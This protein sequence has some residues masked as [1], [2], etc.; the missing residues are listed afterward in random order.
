MRRDFVDSTGRLPKDAQNNEYIVSIIDNFSR[1]L[2]LYAVNDL[3]ANTFARCLLDFTGH[4]GVS[5]ELLI[6][7]KG[8]QFANEIIQE[9]CRA[10]GTEQVFT[11]TAAKKDI[12]IVERSIR[13]S[14][15][16]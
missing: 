5:F 4:Y 7:D 16:H 15:S 8:T 11:M 3:S 2:E 13:E 12:G 10:V 6:S 1:F 9:L 14:A